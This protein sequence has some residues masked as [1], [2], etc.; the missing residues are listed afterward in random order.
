MVAAIALRRGLSV[1]VGGRH[2]LVAD[3]V[4]SVRLGDVPWKE[5][6]GCAL[7]AA[8]CPGL[9]HRHPVHLHVQLQTTRLAD[10]DVQEFVV[11]VLP[12]HLLDFGHDDAALGLLRVEV[13]AEPLAQRHLRADLGVVVT[14]VLTPTRVVAHAKDGQFVGEVQPGELSPRL[15]VFPLQFHRLKDAHHSVHHVPLPAETQGNTICF[16]YCPAPI[17]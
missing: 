9:G 5:V 12:V 17:H 16:Q 4:E 2:G 8:C 13:L 1:A 14:H 7:A 3:G 6:V 11:D 15:E 10:G